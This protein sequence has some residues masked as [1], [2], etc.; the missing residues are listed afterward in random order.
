MPVHPRR[1][2]GA[3]CSALILLTVAPAA[4]EAA[5]GSLTPLGTTPGAGG[6]R[7]IT[8][9]PDGRHV[10]AVAQAESRI[11]AYRREG[12]GLLT[13]VDTETEGSGGV[14]SL[15]GALSVAV[16][17]DGTSVYVAAGGDGAVTSFTRNVATGALTLQ[18][19]VNEGGSGGCAPGSGLGGAEGVA[20]SPDGVSV[21]VAGRNDHALN[22]LART[23]ATGALTYSGCLKDVGAAESCTLGTTQGLG[24]AVQVAVAPDGSSVYV[25]GNSDDAVVNLMRAP[26]GTLTPRNCVSDTGGFCNT[27]TQG[28]DGARA[29]AVSQDGKNVY[30]A[31]QTEDAIVAFTRDATAGD[32]TPLDL[33]Q[34]SIGGVFG[35]NSPEG[36]AVAPDGASVYAGSVDSE[37]VSRLHP[38]R[39]RAPDLP[40]VLQGRRSPVMAA[41]A[42]RGSTDPNA[43]AVP[44]DGSHVYVSS[45][46]DA[47]ATVFARET[48]PPAP[49]GGARRWGRH[50]R[51]R[52]PPAPGRP[53]RRTRPPGRRTSR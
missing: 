51:P 46:G 50:R 28:L 26:N 2:L 33:E 48:P 29:L 21:Y 7:A 4:A 14:T 30:V 6:L 10:Y 27:A 20:V 36:L 25:T 5:P 34:H 41:P 1:A 45:R 31:G 13:P 42:P 47:S 39:R 17:P 19:C 24:G 22:V 37:A 3:I 15:S 53:G 18:G 40:A 52:A 23:P 43:L 44:N 11:T 49:G 35:L 8:T 9:S 32:L 12:S 38:R 16:S